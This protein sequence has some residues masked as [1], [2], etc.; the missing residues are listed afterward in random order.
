MLNSSIWVLRSFILSC[1]PTSSGR[2]ILFSILDICVGRSKVQPARDTTSGRFFNYTCLGPT[3]VFTGPPFLEFLTQYAVFLL[4]CVIENQPLF[5][6]IVATWFL[7]LPSRADFPR[8]DKPLTNSAHILIRILCL[9]MAYMHLG[10]AP[11]FCW[12]QLV[13]FLHL[14]LA[15]QRLSPHCLLPIFWTAFLGC[16]RR[17]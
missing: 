5:I 8:I 17:I 9:R 16:F 7:G 12:Q 15:Q 2:R 1:I 6:A 11:P 4:P 13:F 14:V 10:T 3:T